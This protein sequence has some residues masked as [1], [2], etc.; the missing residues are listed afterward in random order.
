MREKKTILHRELTK[1]DQRVL[2]II[3]IHDQ[4]ISMSQ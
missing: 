1:Y 2:A 3:K 4:S